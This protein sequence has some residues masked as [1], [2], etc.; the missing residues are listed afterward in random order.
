MTCTHKVV[1]RGGGRRGWNSGDRSLW[2]CSLGYE[3][4]FY[5]GPGGR[6]VTFL[7]TWSGEVV[8][9][10]PPAWTLV[11]SPHA[12][13]PNP[14]EVSASGQRHLQERVRAPLILPHFFHQSHCCQHTVHISSCCL[15]TDGPPR[16]K[17]R[18]LGLCGLPLGAQHLAQR[19]AQHGYLVN[20][21]LKWN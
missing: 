10:L 19:L 11:P 12:P 3:G 8:R 16:L 15:F 1:P 20:Y 18:R 5:T 21:L 6:G 13:S 17:E 4:C 2:G 14:L 9:L 7:N